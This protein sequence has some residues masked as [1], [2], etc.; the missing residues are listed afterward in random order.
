MYRNLWPAIAQAHA[1]QAQEERGQA[2]P[3]QAADRAEGRPRRPLRPLREDL[4][5]LG[6]G[7]RRHPARLH[8]RLQQHHELRDAC[9]T[10][11][12]ASRAPT[13]RAIET[14]EQ[15]ALELFRNYD[16]H[17]QRLDRPRTILIDSAALE[18]G[19]EIDK[20]L[21]RRPRHRDRGVPPRARRARDTAAGEITDA[22]ILREVMNTV[23]RKGRLGEQVRCVVSV[24]MLTEGWDANN[25]THIMGLRAFGTRLI[26]EQVIGRALRRLSYDADPETGLFRTEYADIMGI[27]GLNFADQADR[28]PAAA[29]A[30]GRPRPGR[31]PGPRPPRDRL[32]PRRGLPHRL[33]E[34]AHRRRPLPDGALR[35]RPRQGRR[36]RGH[37][38]RASSASRHELDLEH[39]K[40]RAPLDDRVPHR[41]TT[42]S[43]HKLRDAERRAEDAPLPARQ[44]HRPASGSKSDRLVCKGG[45]IPAQLLYRQLTDE[46]CDLLDGRA[47]RPARRAIRSS[48]PRSTRSRPKARPPTSTS[49]PPRPAATGPGPTAATSTGSSPTATGRPSSPRS[50]TSTRASPP[51]PRTTTSASRCPTLREGEPHRYRPDFLVRLRPAG[52]AARHPRRRG[53]GLPRPRRA[54]Q[55]RDDAQQVDPRRQPP[56]HASAAGA[57]PSSAPSTTSA[58]SSTPPS[59]PSWRRS[60]H[61]R[62]HLR[63]PRGPPPARGLGARGARLHPVARREHRPPLR[64]HRHPARA[65]RAGG[66]RSRRFAADIL[67]RNPQDDSVVLIENQ[68]EQTDH[69]HLGQIMT[70]LAGLEA[71]TVVWIAPPSA[72]RTSPPSAGST[73]TPPTASPSSPSGSASSASATAPTPRSSRSWRSRTTGTASSRGQ[74]QQAER[75]VS[76]IGDARADF[77]TAYLERHPE[78]GPT[79]GLRRARADQHLACRDAGRRASSSGSAANECGIYVRGASGAAGRARSQKHLEPHRRATRAARSERPI[80][81]GDRNGYFLARPSPPDLARPATLADDH[82]LAWRSARSATSPR[83]TRYVDG[84]TPA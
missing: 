23:G 78:R 24:S 54:A 84:E 4:P 14:V 52:R 60:R 18:S 49:P 67:A 58:P 6:E 73:S 69:T 13:T 72:S 11:S 5:R 77:W 41:R 21:P 46:V 38:V 8:R 56:R 48:A 47:P 31:Q 25:V 59:T 35:A 43:S 19:G 45:T 44:A 2:R 55:G 61:D 42:G 33:P 64:G 40:R 57:S 27:D 71:Q 76:D 63:P 10:T 70:Y 65:D 26:C 9:A 29:A 51:T 7:G 16:D 39:L 50:S 81:P 74:R 37:D 15:G 22:E 79:C 82:R 28:Q 53:Q 30:R 80:G 36:D 66:A 83:S 20:A 75:S 68:L 62:D 1:G 32:P 17:E 12:P 3:A 34:G